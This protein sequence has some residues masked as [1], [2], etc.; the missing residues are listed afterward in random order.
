MTRRKYADLPKDQLWLSDFKHVS[1]EAEEAWAACNDRSLDFGAW[2]TPILTL[3][4][5]VGTG[6]SHLLQGIGRIAVE[7]GIT[8]KYIYVPD[9][10]ERL[11]S[12]YNGSEDLSFD[13]IYAPL[14]EATLLL[15]DDIGAERQ[16][17]FTQETVGRVVDY[18][19]REGL[20]TVITTN[21]VSF[22]DDAPAL[23]GARLADR[24]FDENSGKVS[25][26]YTGKVSYRTAPDYR[27]QRKI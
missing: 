15:M 20:Q 11:R 7:A 17:P 6:K 13:E 16:S 3:M 9:W 24:I 25:V 19:C 23:L 14:Q 12:T 1:P 26:V 2:P 10:L 22:E 21:V 8:T 18:R 5:R 4:G 27:Q